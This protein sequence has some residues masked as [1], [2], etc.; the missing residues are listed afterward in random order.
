LTKFVIIQGSLNKNSKTAIVLNEIDNLLN[1]ERKIHTELIDLRDIELEWCDGRPS[2]QYNDD[3]QRCRKIIN[4]ADGIIIGMPVYCYSVS[5][6]LKNFLDIVI[7]SMDSKVAGVVCQ[8]GGIRSFLAS[9][10]LMK[11]LS[12]EADV[13]SVQ[14]V[15]HTSVADF[16]EGKLVNQGTFEVINQMIDAI[17]R[18]I[19]SHLDVKELTILK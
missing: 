8:S 4:E 14:P 7:G 2:S 10:D 19:P 6:P 18:Y 11:I 13:I 16:N 17:L 9:A 5:G 12:F 1:E 3:L 15:V